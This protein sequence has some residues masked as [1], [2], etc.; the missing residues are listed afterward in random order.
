[1]SSPVPEKDEATSMRAV[2]IKN[3]F[4]DH[5]S[6]HLASGIERN[7]RVVHLNLSKNDFSEDGAIHLGRAIGANNSVEE[8]DLSWNQIRKKGAVAICNGLSRN[9]CISVVNLAWNGFAYEGAVAVGE[10]LRGNKYLREIDISSNRINWEGAL[11]VM[12]GLK[13]NDTLEVLKIGHNPLTMT[14]CLD[15]LEA[16]DNPIILRCDPLKL[17]IQFLSDKGIR[18][19]DLFRTFDK[20]NQH[21]V[22]REQFIQGLKKAKVPLDDYE[23]ERVLNRLDAAKEGKI[24]YQRLM[25]GVKEQIKVNRAEE[26]RKMLEEKRQMEEHKRI[27]NLPAI[28]ETNQ[29]PVTK[30]MA[31]LS[32][33]R[34]SSA[35]SMSTVMTNLPGSLRSYDTHFVSS[36]TSVLSKASSKA[37]LLSQTSSRTSLPKINMTAP[38]GQQGRT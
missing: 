7:E 14:G 37:S 19:V 18:P 11:Q 20:D 3:H 31:S 25:R 10:M 27:M 29:V 5:D 35:S 23:L 21:K 34:P 33:P 22:S 6:E 30:S 1:M 12:K 9:Y 36:R 13:E 15:I 24:S 4:N 32:Q 16:V 2:E 38:L 26:K 17:L 8:L 28:T